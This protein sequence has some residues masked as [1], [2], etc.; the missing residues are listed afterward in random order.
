MAALRGPLAALERDVD[1]VDAWGRRLG[2][3]L[4]GGGRL[5]AAGNGGSAALAQHLT[6]ELVGRFRDDRP[7]LSAL[8]LH[9]ETSSVTAIGNDYGAAEV[10]ARQVRAHGRS[11]DVL[12]A[13]STSGGSANVVDAAAAARDAGVLVWGLTGPG[14]NPLTVRCDDAVCVDAPTTAT[15]QEVH[16][17]VVHLLCAAVDVE[18][19]RARGR[20]DA[21]VGGGGAA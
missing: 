17:V 11:G 8:A 5:L 10:F 4:L 19:A 3:V 6:S 9:A 14:P 13:I 15:V 2:A 1:R 16:Q 12:V 7:P 18:V 20:V 21:A